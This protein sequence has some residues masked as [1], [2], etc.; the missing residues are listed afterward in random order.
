MGRNGFG[1]YILYLDTRA[2]SEITAAKQILIATHEVMS[3]TVSIEWNT[4]Q[5]ILNNYRLQLESDLLLCR[6]IKI[7]S[8]ALKYVG[9]NM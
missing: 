9:D 8:Y 2:L 7:S 5:S 6:F 3:I 1:V 4:L